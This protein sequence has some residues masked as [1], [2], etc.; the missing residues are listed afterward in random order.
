MPLPAFLSVYLVHGV[1]NSSNKF[2]SP[3][4]S[5]VH[6]GTTLRGQNLTVLTGPGK[7][8]QGLWWDCGKHQINYNDLCEGGEH[9]EPT[10][11]FVS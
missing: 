2:L 4:N 1:N 5:L 7:Q 6:S 9:R 8:T 10:R 11:L 3:S